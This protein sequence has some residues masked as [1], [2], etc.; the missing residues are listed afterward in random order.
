M[1]NRVSPNMITEAGIDKFGTMISDTKSMTFFRSL[2]EEIL[3]S[4]E[5]LN[6]NNWISPQWE[7]GNETI[8]LAVFV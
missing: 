1:T 8:K 3:Q 4:S 5:L 7:E 6:E 2:G